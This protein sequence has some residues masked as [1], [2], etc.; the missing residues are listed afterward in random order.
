MEELSH[1]FYGKWSDVSRLGKQTQ[2]LRGCLPQHTDRA[3]TYMPFF[4]T[5]L[6]FVLCAAFKE[7]IIL[8]PLFLVI[9]AKD[10]TLKHF[11]Y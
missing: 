1:S 3:S 11:I 4:L 7:R 5:L 2:H 10:N 8:L 6:T 9:S